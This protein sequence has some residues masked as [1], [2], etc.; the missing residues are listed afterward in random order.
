MKP[1][2]FNLRWILLAITFCICFS[3]QA[4]M[5]DKKENAD[6]DKWHPE[7]FY[8]V[9]P[10][11]K[12]TFELPYEKDRSGVANLL[13]REKGGT[14]HL[15]DTIKNNGRYYNRL[16]GKYDAILLYNNGKY[17][18]CDDVVFEKDVDSQIDMEKLSVQPA[19][20]D[21]QQWLTL[22]K[23]TDSI[24]GRE[25]VFIKKAVSERKMRGYLLIEDGFA[26]NYPL[27]GRKECTFDGYFE[28][29]PDDETDTLTLEFFCIGHNFEHLAVEANSGIFY[30]LDSPGPGETKNI[31]TGPTIKR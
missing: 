16:S 30:I 18:V 3:M 10:D 12:L 1:I 22:R 17:I 21:S 8:I 9:Y 14:I 28:V 6:E 5:I 13:F 15:L 31:T 24:G 7:N 29:D 26:S 23:F 20:S 11:M 19:D 4:N 25:R 27:V 2:S